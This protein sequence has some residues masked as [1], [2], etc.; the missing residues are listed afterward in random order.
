MRLNRIFGG[1]G[2]IALVVVAVPLVAA[3]ATPAGQTPAEPQVTLCHGTNSDANPY[4]TTTVDA[5]GAYDAHL[6]HTGP[7]WNSTLKDD[8][9]AWGDIIPPFTLAGQVYSLN[10]PAG[11]AI[12]ANDC[13]PAPAA[14]TAVTAAAPMFT[15][16]TCAVDPSYAVPSQPT[17]IVQSVTGAD[18]LP[19]WGKTVTV[20]F[21][22]AVS[23]TLTGLAA[24]SHAFGAS[25]DCRSV[26]IPSDPSVTSAECDHATG[27]V[28]GFAITP[29]STE[30][31]VYTVV[32]NVVT[33]TA[34]SGYQLGALPTG[35]DSTSETVATFVVTA[36][37][38]NCLIDV[39]PAAP[40]VVQSA[41]TGPGTSSAPSVAAAVTTGISYSVVNDLGTV[42]A[43]VHA[44]Y[45]FGALADGWTLHE[46]VAVFETHLL[47]PGSCAVAAQ[48]SAP[49]FVE[50]V[51]VGTTST[52]PSVVLVA[53]SGVRYE[54]DGQAA[55]A[56]TYPAVSGST[57][58]VAAVATDGYFVAGTAQWTHTFGAPCSGAGG[59]GSGQP[60]V[61]D[62]PASDPPASDPPVS[63][64]PASD[65]P[66]SDPP[67]SHSA[68]SAGGLASTGVPTRTLLWSGAALVLGGL[69]V[70]LAGLKPQRARH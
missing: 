63:D 23:Y 61:S 16:G 11:Q 22:A 50:Q 12:F 19:L 36:A 13:H 40:T 25:P 69:A 37:E 9:I 51:C 44:G 43:T 24:Y 39:S 41:C 42:S 14:P 27:I 48:P 62:P 8:H 59:E 4:N 55:A 35:W 3:Q 34:T 5:S 21:S 28:S 65:P 6:G 53:S 31:I 46:G 1:L 45:E 67:V 64:P 29:A 10:W 33:A 7:V 32:G 20:T 30:G 56:D 70:F 68:A 57:V 52:G 38:D 15:D 2:V 58:V 54:V 18:V 66:A 60:P 47:S 49:M 26:A 17:G